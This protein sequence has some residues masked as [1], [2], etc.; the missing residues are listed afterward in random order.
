MFAIRFLP[1]MPEGSVIGNSAPPGEIVLGD[2][3]ES[4]TSLIGFWSPLDY[5]NHWVSALHRLVDERKRSCLIT[6]L[7]DLDVAEIL[8]WWLLYPDGDDARVQN[9]LLPLKALR[10]R[11]DSSDPYGAIAPHRTVN[12]DGLEISEWTVPV[13]AIRAFLG[14]V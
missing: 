9:A 2:Y 12:D 4:F 6:S 7:H 8:H 10:P 11:F 13:T 14:S 5:Q 1:E 3:Q